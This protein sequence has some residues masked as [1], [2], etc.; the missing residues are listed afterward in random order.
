MTTTTPNASANA[1]KKR[2][3]ARI[4]QRLGHMLLALCLVAGLTPTI[5]L[6][7]TAQP[8]TTAL[9]EQPDLVSSTQPAD[10]TQQSEPGDPSAIPAYPDESASAANLVELAAEGTRNNPNV[11]VG[12]NVVELTQDGSGA[13]FYQRGS[14]A[15]VAYTGTITLLGADGNARFVVKGGHDIV[16]G[17]A[18]IGNSILNPGAGNAAIDFQ[19]ASGSSSASS[20]LTIASGTTT[21]LKGGTDAP[22]INVVKG[23]NLTIEGDGTLD[24]TGSDDCPAIGVSSIGNDEFGNLYFE[25]TGTVIARGTAGAPALGDPNPTQSMATGTIIFHSGTTKLTGGP[26]FANDLMAGFIQVYGGNIQLSH[27]EPVMYQGYAED[28]FENVEVT[29]LAISGLPAGAQISKMTIRLNGMTYPAGYFDLQYNARLGGYCVDGFDTVTADQTVCLLLPKTQVKAGGELSVEANGQTY[30]GPLVASS[31]TGGCTVKLV[32]RA[33]ITDENPTVSLSS[34]KDALVLRDD[35]GT[36][37][38][39]STDNGATWRFYEGHFTITGSTSHRGIRI[40]SGRHEVHLRNLIMEDE[41]LLVENSANVDLVLIGTNGINPIYNRPAIALGHQSTLTISGKGSLGAS[42][43][44]E[45]PAI[46]SKNSGTSGGDSGA[47]GCSASLIIKGGTIVASSTSGA[48]I[49]AGSEATLG[50]ISIQGGNVTAYG[51]TNTARSLFSPGIGSGPSYASRVQSISISGG[52]VTAIGNGGA[53]IGSSHLGTVGSITISG[54]DVTARAQ[55]R[56]DVPGIGGHCA[57]LTITG[58]TITASSQ[59]GSGV[60]SSNKTT[61]TGGTVNG[62][63]LR[64]PVPDTKSAA[65]AQLLSAAEDHA[66]MPLA[67]EGADIALAAEG[68]ETAADV[69]AF[70]AQVAEDASLAD[71]SADDYVAADIATMVS[72]PVNELD[73]ELVPVVFSG[74]PASTSLSSVD[75]SIVN[76]DLVDDPTQSEDYGVRDV[77]TSPEGTLTFYLTSGEAYKRLVLASWGGKMYAGTIEQGEGDVMT[78]ALAETDALLFYEGH[79]FEGGWQC[80]DD[81]IAWSTDGASTETRSGGDLT[82]LCFETPLAGVTVRYATDNGSGFGPWAED[83]DIAGEME[84]P[85]R[86]LRVS[87]AGDAAAGRSVVYRML[88][89]DG[90]W[91]PWAADGEA[92]AVIEGAVAK[93][94][95]A[96]IVPNGQLDEII[97]DP[98]ADQAS[99]Q[100]S[101]TASALASTGD[102]RVADM[103][104]ALALAMLAAAALLASRRA[105]RGHYR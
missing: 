16:L 104:A 39:Y 55:Q 83:G 41:T 94:V 75:F 14:E 21:T 25:H 13:R 29:S 101:K 80:E 45:A 18:E 49:G 1:T 23:V 99:D 82:A 33:S 84:E 61:I 17:D 12:P 56:D 46:G 11:Y 52:T 73:E 68:F 87:L 85:I 96:K 97:A 63:A 7:D 31:A 34:V 76:I 69:A 57:A 93:A 6:A 102:A 50:S 54:G 98:A 77:A 37:K 53:G 64:T 72:D 89:S 24:A 28:E 79:T 92:T 86:S 2:A 65:Q 42:T 78:C 60:L 43:T 10:P 95:Q 100:P 47:A 58:G 44:G 51:N 38:Q 8:A 36:Q 20:T 3:R 88:L 48:G 62:Q 91:T 5:A 27:K 103:A 66:V 74:L 19:P 9:S 35:S 90:T 30:E 15:P 67:D 32:S 105:Q 70:A 59:S 71:T 40:T 81:G 4:A 22:A 26:N